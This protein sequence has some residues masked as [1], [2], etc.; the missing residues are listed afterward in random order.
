MVILTEVGGL[1]FLKQRL[2][3]TLPSLNFTM[4]SENQPSKQSVYLYYIHVYTFSK[5]L[6]ASMYLV[7]YHLW[8]W[9][10]TSNHNEGGWNKKILENSFLSETSWLLVSM[11][12]F[13][14]FVNYSN[15]ILLRSNRQYIL[16]SCCIYDAFIFCIQ[17]P[18]PVWGR[19]NHFGHL[20]CCRLFTLQLLL[21]SC[22]LQHGGHVFRENPPKPICHITVHMSVDGKPN[23]N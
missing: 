11:V 21:A 17:P 15:Y 12:F 4:K 19:T 3:T 2:A 14:V 18:P 13:R 1:G 7:N 23:S 8:F 16:A 6:A 10:L 5:L 9:Q 22:W 20:F